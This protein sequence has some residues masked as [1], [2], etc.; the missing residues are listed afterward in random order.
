MFI[1]QP[2]IIVSIFEYC[3]I[4][5][6]KNILLTCIINDK[7]SIVKYIKNRA[8]LNIIKFMTLFYRKIK[9][10]KNIENNLYTD[11]RFT[12]KLLAFHYFVLYKREYIDLLINEQKGWKKTLLEEYPFVRKNTYTRYEMYRIIAGIKVIDMFVIGW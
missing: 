7:K 5:E 12:K 9:F 11:I 10:I 8:A 6:I 4:I 1:Y 2:E 3:N